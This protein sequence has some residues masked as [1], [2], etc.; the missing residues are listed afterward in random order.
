MKEFYRHLIAGKDKDV[1][2]S[3]ARK[4]VMIEN[5]NPFYWAPFILVGEM[6]R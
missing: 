4:E 6:K 1:A 5:R 2:L 3:L